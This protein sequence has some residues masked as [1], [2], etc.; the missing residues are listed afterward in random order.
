MRTA[1]ILSLWVAFVLA[2]GGAAGQTNLW[3]PVG[4]R[5]SYRLYW[6]MIRVGTAELTTEWIAFDGGRRLAI[7]ARART[8]PFMSKIYAVDDWIETIVEPE[9]FLPIR[10]EQRLNEG[11]HRR[12]DLFIFDHPGRKAHWRSMLKQESHV[13]DIGAD[14]RDVLSLVYYMRSQPFAI[15]D[16]RRFHVVVDDKLYD[17]TVAGRKTETLTGLDGADVQCLRVE[18]QAKFGEIFVRKGRLNLW[19]TD[20]RSRVCL[21]MTGKMPIASV[22]AVLVDIS[23]PDDE[24]DAGTAVDEVDAG[25]ME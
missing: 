2:A 16:E 19:F 11:R 8:T 7:C 18:P 15:G 24:S 13:V 12:H 17:L 6:G 21:L 10:Y 20:D 9:S 23:G 14:T 1:R 5:L 4:E 25:E 3:F 22:K